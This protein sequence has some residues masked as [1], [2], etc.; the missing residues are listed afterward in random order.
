MS[1]LII[2]ET[3]YIETPFGVISVASIGEPD[4]I[5][6]TPFDVLEGAKI[7]DS[8]N[9][10]LTIEKNGEKNSYFIGESSDAL[11]LSA[12]PTGKNVYGVLISEDFKTQEDPFADLV[13]CDVTQLIM[14]YFTASDKEKKLP[15]EVVLI[16]SNGLGYQMTSDSDGAVMV[17]KDTKDKIFESKR[18]S[19]IGRG[20]NRMVAY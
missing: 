4:P 7:L 18:K 8:S 12:K 15:C 10:M 5:D 20:D 11:F 3:G 6:Y 19:V 9:N 2:K 17:Y 14:N 1:E 16:G 13:G